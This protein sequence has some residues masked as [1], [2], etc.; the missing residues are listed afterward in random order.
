MFIIDFYADNSIMLMFAFST[1]LLFNTIF[2][3]VSEHALIHFS[4]IANFN[5]VL[6]KS[7]ANFPGKKNCC[8][9]VAE[10]DSGHLSFFPRHCI[11]RKGLACAIS[12]C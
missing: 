5:F 2:L 7:Q 11:L 12:F 8:E 1:F 10:L 6:C 3:T 9:I 4:P